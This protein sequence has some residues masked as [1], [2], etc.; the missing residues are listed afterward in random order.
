L[1]RITYTLKHIITKK[2]YNSGKI[3]G[4][5]QDSSQEFIS[6]LATIYAN[7]TKILPALIYKGT[8]GNLQDSWLE[9]LKK[10]QYAFFVLLANR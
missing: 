2:L 4:A 1:I 3:K 7:G 9:D 8:S 5:K 10:K 6:L